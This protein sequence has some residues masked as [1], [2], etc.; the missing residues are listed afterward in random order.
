MKPTT[1]MMYAAL[2]AAE[3]LNVRNPAIKLGFQDVHNIVAAAL[4]AE[5]ALTLDESSCGCT[6]GTCNAGKRLSVG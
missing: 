3:R 2:Q 6:S 4:E 1:S 5:P